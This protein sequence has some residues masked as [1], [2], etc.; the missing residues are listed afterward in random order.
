L[1]RVAKV[2]QDVPTTDDGFES[3]DARLVRRAAWECGSFL[4]SFAELDW[5]VAIPDMDWDASTAISHAA[6]ALIWYSMDLSA[7]FEELSAEEVGVKPG[8]APRELVRTIR[9]ASYVLASVIEC[10]RPE[11]RGFHPWGMADASGFAAMACDEMILHTDDAA[12]GLGAEFTP[13]ANIARST[14]ERLFP[15]APT[16]DDPWA[17]LKWANGRGELPDRPRLTKWHWHC[18]PLS[19][20]DGTDPTS[21]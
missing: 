16:G 1:V 3:F 18:A 15:W 14:V 10:T 2:G 21:S 11:V 17:T 9:T 6:T 20:W 8:S 4:D 19:E 5:T 12:R 13:S 7:G